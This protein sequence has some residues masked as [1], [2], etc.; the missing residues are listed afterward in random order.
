RT[1]T[2][3]NSPA[4]TSRRDV[5]SKGWNYR[6]IARFGSSISSTC[7][8]SSPE[9]RRISEELLVIEM[10]AHETLQRFRVSRKY[11]LVFVSFVRLFGIVNRD[12]AQR[13]GMLLEPI[14]DPLPAQ[15][16]QLHRS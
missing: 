3:R 15:Q 2:A 16:P 8:G 7:S 1:V 4:G 6:N 14:S 12:V 11:D 10:C 13:V 9:H 5:S